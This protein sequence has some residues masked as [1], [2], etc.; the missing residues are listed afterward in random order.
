MGREKI[1]VDLLEIGGCVRVHL[2]QLYADLM[3]TV[4]HVDDVIDR[5]G[6]AAFT[7]V[8]AAGFAT[9]NCRSRRSIQSSGTARWTHGQTL[10][11]QVHH[12]DIFLTFPC[13]HTEQT[14][15]GRFWF[16]YAY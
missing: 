15:P 7:P 9:V 6:I 11:N 13:R 1:D 2:C 14:D 3:R 12:G 10:G 8:F 4:R 5:R 16:V